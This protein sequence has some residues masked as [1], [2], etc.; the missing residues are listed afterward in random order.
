VNGKTRGRVLVI[1]TGG[2][3][4]IKAPEVIRELIDRGFEVKAVMTGTASHFIG[5]QAIASVSSH[6]VYDSLFGEEPSPHTA[7]ASWAEAVAVV[8]AT[9][10][11]MAKVANGIADDLASTLLL[12]YPGKVIFA[13]AMHEQMWHSAATRRNVASLVSDGHRVLPVGN[14]R[15]AGGDRGWGR[16]LDTGWIVSAIEH[17]AFGSPLDL[18]GINV[19]VSAGGTREP[20]D[21]VRYLGNR[22][23]GKQGAAIAR[24]AALLGAEVRLVSSVDPGFGG[25]PV[26]I[27]QVETAEDMAHGMLSNASWADWI[28]MAAAV[29]DFAPL[30]LDKP[31][32]IKRRERESLEI[33]C[34]PTRDILKELVKNRRDG[35]IVVGFAA[36]VEGLEAEMQRKLTEK[37][38]D[39]LVGNDVTQPGAGFA[40]STNAVTIISRTGRRW[41]LPV[42]DKE[43]VARRLL[44][45][46]NDTRTDTSN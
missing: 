46:I 17:V 23:S 15:L 33:N 1:I 18:S 10:D 19:L 45:I 35:Q 25:G 3:A 7:L 11:F 13:P 42:M 6:P 2:I 12:A 20:V 44:G 34:M 36:E 21:S 16:M 29:A 24:I 38:V 30:R 26:E 27:T 31:S 8:P 4:A 14:G 39:F 5:K 43:Q 37:G 32:K 41:D 9:A 40:G 28:V 22:S